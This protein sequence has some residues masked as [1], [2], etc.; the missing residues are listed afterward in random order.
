MPHRALAPPAAIAPVTPETALSPPL[1][2][3]SLDGRGVGDLTFIV[4]RVAGD[5]ARWGRLLSN[6]LGDF[7]PAAAAGRSHI[8]GVQRANRLIYAIELTPAGTV[9]Q[10]CGRANLAPNDQ[11]RRAIHRALADLLPDLRRVR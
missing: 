1:A 10:F 2:I 7:G 3:R 4:P 9:R 11:D 5:L 6:C 8:I